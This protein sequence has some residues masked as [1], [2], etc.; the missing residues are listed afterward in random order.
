MMF[1]KKMYEFPVLLGLKMAFMMVLIAW[2]TYTHVIQIHKIY[3]IRFFKSQRSF[4]PCYNTLYEEINI[5]H[6]LL[7]LSQASYI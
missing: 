7:C 5:N 1:D 2:I 4:S 6:T 3:E